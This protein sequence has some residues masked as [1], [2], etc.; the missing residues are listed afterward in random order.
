MNEEK[1][2]CFIGHRKINAT[3]ELKAILCEIIEK[4]ITDENVK[5]FL[6]G[7]RSQFDDLCIETVTK[8]K[9]KYPEIKA[10]ICT[11]RISVYY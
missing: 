8:L 10:N 9:Q 2:C 5:V 6:F 7:S 11:G 1:I 3:E 4:L